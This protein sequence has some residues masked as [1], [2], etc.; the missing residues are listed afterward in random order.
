MCSKSKDVQGALK[1]LPLRT[2]SADYHLLMKHIK[3]L[4][5]SVL[6]AAFLFGAI[7]L[8]AADVKSYQV[9]GPVLAVTPTTITVQKGDEKWEIGRSKNTKLTGDP[10]VGSKVTIYYTMTA[11]EIEVKEPKTKK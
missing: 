7:S 4:S 1:G 9:T 10:K 6:C 11:T 3:S 8:H 2:F 5:K